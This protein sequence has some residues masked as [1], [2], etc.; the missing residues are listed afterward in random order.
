MGGEK[1]TFA[2]K[3]HF[4]KMHGYDE[5]CGQKE[6]TKEYKYIDKN[7]L[8]NWGVKDFDIFKVAK[9]KYKELSKTKKPL[10]LTISTLG[11]HF[12]N[13]TEDNRCKNSHSN[14][15]INTVECTNDLISRFHIISRKTRKLQRHN[16][17]TNPRSYYDG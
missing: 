1:R 5:I 6:L 13:G 3:Y 7:N 11:N 4:L 15:M 17:C 9:E 12:P 10:N 14:G 8:T 16:N 2:G